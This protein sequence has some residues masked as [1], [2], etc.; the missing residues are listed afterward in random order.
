MEKQGITLREFI[1][2]YCP[3][4]DSISRQNTLKHTI[5]HTIVYPTM[6][7]SS[8]FPMCTDYIHKLAKCLC[9]NKASRISKLFRACSATSIALAHREQKYNLKSLCY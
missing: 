3:P 9:I 8:C 5:E 1:N 2:R 7:N 6:K 4:T